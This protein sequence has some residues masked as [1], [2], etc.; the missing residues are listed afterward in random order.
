[1][2]VEVMQRENVLTSSHFKTPLF[3]DRSNIHALFPAILKITRNLLNHFRNSIAVNS[4]QP[5]SEIAQASN[6]SASEYV[7]ANI[8]LVPL[9]NPD[10]ISPY[11]VTISPQAR[12][13]RCNL[14]T[15]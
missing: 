6:L 8:Q 13:A 9:Q 3:L 14:S 12:P 5:H 15:A 2:V 11:A 4:A 10:D 1:M 7:P